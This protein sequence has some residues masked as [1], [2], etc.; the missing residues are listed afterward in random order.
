MDTKILQTAFYKESVDKTLSLLESSEYGLTQE[1]A[2]RRLAQCGR[3]VLPE[4][5]RVSVIVIFFK[6]FHNLLVYILLA[7]AAVSLSFGHIIDFSV[8]VVVVLING[9]F[10]FLQ[11]YRSEKAIEALKTLVKDTIKVIRGGQIKEIEVHSLVPGDIMFIEAG[12]K[13]PADGRVV[14]VNNLLVNEASLTGESVPQ[15]KKTIPHKKTLPSPERSN[16]VYSG[17]VVVSG[18]GKVVVTATGKHSQ[19]GKI[20]TGVQSTQREKGQFMLKVNHLAKVL[21]LIALIGSAA[22]MFIGFLRGFDRFSVFLLGVASA[23]SGI[24][25]GLPVVLAIVL[26]IG[27]QRMAKKNAIVKHLSSVEPLGMADVICVD[28]TG[29]LTKNIMTVTKIFVAGREYDISGTG[30]ELSGEYWQEGKKILPL[31]DPFLTHLLTVGSIVHHASVL[32]KDNQEVEVVG[33][34][35]EAALVVAA[36]KAG[37]V[38]EELLI[39]HNL[40]DTIPFSS[41]TK[42]QA[43]LVQRKDQ[44]KKKY[45]VYMIGALETLLPRC[46]SAAWD[47]RIVNL[48]KELRENITREHKKLANHGYRVIAA[49]YR[50]HPST[51]KD[52]TQ[53]SLNDMVFLGFFAIID[54]PRDEVK[55]SVEQSRNAGIRL[56]MLTGDSKDTAVAIGKQVGLIDGKIAEGAVY[57]DLE[58]RGMNDAQFTNMA[59]KVAIL[60]RVAPLT[61]LRL[62][63]TL[64]KNGHIVAMTGDG[65]NDAPALKKA[66]I[67]VAMGKVGTD[68]AR[69]AAEIILFDDNFASLVNAIEEGRVVFNNVRR[70]SSYLVT[71]N[72]AQY[73]TLIVALLLGLPMPLLPLQILWMNL[74]TD[75]FSDISLATEP[76]HGDVLKRPPHPKG[77][78]ILNREVVE[79]I[80]IVG[81]LMV[82]GTL[83]V[84]Y[85]LLA[86]GQTAYGR[87]MMFATM[88]MF[89]LW[90][91]FNMRSMNKSIFQLGFFSNKY[92]NF[93][94]LGALTLQFVVLYVPK[95]QEIFSFTPLSLR[96]WLIIVPLTFSVIIGVEV[97]KFF[98]FKEKRFLQI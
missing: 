20:A 81:V 24:P 30:Y 74:V 59:K 93:G 61:K 66:D 78:T 88:S 6:Q 26:A 82:V 36:A 8:I 23:V 70:T 31:T 94:L 16:M 80:F 55:S 18:E 7:A 98:R 79:L 37:L 85:P 50:K 91:I 3:N 68:V 28:K 57:T 95:L 13:I 65:V 1:E 43:A 25:E 96:D 14:Y 54:P 47:D 29:T 48:G 4:A 90:N 58:V 19:L 32:Q 10:G 5:L 45:E 38:K 60:A 40:L 87:T 86:S 56:I 33:D 42:Y 97:Y 64:Q 77:T 73:L 17:T 27:V 2:D 72:V 52:I 15:H 63:E 71:T 39:E 83:L 75:G 76:T 44:G 69:E 41:E 62:V 49:A 46:G 51:P 53:A 9:I 89:Q 67:G 11:E 35:T 12:D 21:G 92:I 84:G 34:P 22:V